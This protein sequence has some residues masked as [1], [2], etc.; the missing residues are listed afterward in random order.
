VRALEAH[1]TF[2][3]ALDLLAKLHARQGRRQAT[4][5]FA[6]RAQAPGVDLRARGRR[7]MAGIWSALA[8]ALVGCAWVAWR[9]ARSPALPSPRAA[10]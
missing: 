1:P 10:D 3:P 6:A 9:E 4:R 7:L 5:P 8:L 2:A